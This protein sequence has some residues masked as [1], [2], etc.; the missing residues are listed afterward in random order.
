MEIRL[1]EADT[2][3]HSGGLTDISGVAVALD[4]GGKSAWGWDHPPNKNEISRR[5]ALQTVHAA[6]AQ[7]GRIPGA[8]VCPPDAASFG[9]AACNTS[10]IWTGPLLESAASSASD[11]FS[12]VTV[13]LKFA[14]FSA[15]KLS[16]SAF[17]SKNED[18]SMILMIE[19]DD[20]SVENDEF[21]DR[22]CQI[23]QP[24]Q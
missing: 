16:L 13:T 19:N 14:E 23:R 22:G 17:L 24:G 1:A 7:Q 5:L 10:S 11:G 4:C 21:C 8:V 2:A 3:P 15:E 18:S 20:S 9:P 12:T 6:Y